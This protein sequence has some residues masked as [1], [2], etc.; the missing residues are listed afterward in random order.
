[1]AFKGRV[2]AAPKTPMLIAGGYVQ[3]SYLVAAMK[4]SYSLHD[5]FAFRDHAE[6]FRLGDPRLE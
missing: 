2:D 5:P 6:V 1:M 4:E 3:Q